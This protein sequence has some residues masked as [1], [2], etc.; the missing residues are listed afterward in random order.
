M[1]FLHWCRSKLVNM[2]VQQLLEQR[3]RM[4][5]VIRYM[6]EDMDNNVENIEKTE[7]AIHDLVSLIVS[8]I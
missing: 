2:N 6:L 5:D 4:L 1:F 3:Q 8:S 7:K